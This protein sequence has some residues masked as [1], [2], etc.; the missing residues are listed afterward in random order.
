MTDYYTDEY[1]VCVIRCEH[2]PV[3][4]TGADYGSRIQTVSYNMDDERVSDLG[5]C[6]RVSAS[7]LHVE[8]LPTVLCSTGITKTS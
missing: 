6:H 3:I 8:I 7:R 1:G 4:A 2:G 5:V